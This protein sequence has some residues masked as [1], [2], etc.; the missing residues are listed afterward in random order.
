MSPPQVLAYPPTAIRNVAAGR[1]VGNP[2]G[3][4]GTRAKALT[5]SELRACAE[6]YSS[7]QVDVIAAA[8]T[9][10]INAKY[11]RPGSG[12][13]SSDLAAAVQTSLGR[14]DNALLLSGGTLTGALSL[15]SNALTCGAITASGTVSIGTVS[16]LLD[17]GSELITQISAG[18]A[19]AVGASFAQARASHWI[20]F[21]STSN[22]QDAGDVRAYRGGPGIWQQRNGLNAQ[23]FEL[24]ETFTSATNYG[25]LCL[26][27]T[28]S[29]HQ[30]GSA[31]G[32]AG[33]NNRAVQIGHFSSAGAF[34]AGLSIATSGATTFQTIADASAPNNSVYYSSTQS[35]LVYKDAAGAVNALY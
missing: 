35:K 28:A 22:A 27:A 1:V 6:A 8:L 23:T 33:G 3:S 25:S 18:N 20:G 15:G 16:R 7:A 12:I 9:S 31:R 24:F 17:T 34:T 19:W 14:A 10:A 13:P 26:K 29:G 30:I 32:S 5:A 21:A 4:S 11:T 2:V